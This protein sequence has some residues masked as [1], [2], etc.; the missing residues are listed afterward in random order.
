MDKRPSFLQRL[1]A[2][3]GGNRDWYS[4]PGRRARNEQTVR[5]ELIIPEF[6]KRDS[7]TTGL[8]SSLHALD[9]QDLDFRFRLELWGGM[10]SAEAVPSNYVRMAYASPNFETPAKAIQLEQLD[11]ASSTRKQTHRL[12]DEGQLLLSL[13][14]LYAYDD[15][16]RWFQHVGKQIIALDAL[17]GTPAVLDCWK[18]PR[19]S[20]WMLQA[21]VV[22][23]R[24]Q[25]VLS[26]F[27]E[28][29]A[30]STLQRLAPVAGNDR[31]AEWHDASIRHMRNI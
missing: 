4:A 9:I 21:F 25:A 19:R 26:G 28:K 16:E 12:T 10:I 29:E 20:Y 31:L 6:S 2:A 18:G 15:S 17:P 3:M 22:D 8:Y 27:D 7:F 24:L 1:R 30:V 13:Q 14:S 11:I 5:F 23:V